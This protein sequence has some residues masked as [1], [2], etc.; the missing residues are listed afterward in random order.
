[1]IYSFLIEFNLIDSTFM[2]EFIILIQTKLKS[3]ELV[4]AG[5]IL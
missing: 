4:D 5:Y 1:M 3:S 2:F